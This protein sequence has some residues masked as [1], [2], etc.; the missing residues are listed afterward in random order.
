[1]IVITN[2]VCYR[3]QWQV[4]MT[5]GSY[6]RQWHVTGDNDRWHF[7]WNYIDKKQGNDTEAD[8]SEMMRRCVTVTGF[9]EE[10]RK[11]LLVYRYWIEYLHYL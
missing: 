9:N 8:Y 5:G 11:P 6:R 10:Y 3:W 4:K 1:M 7:G 2:G